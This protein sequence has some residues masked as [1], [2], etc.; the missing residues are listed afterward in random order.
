M[1]AF[2]EDISDDVIHGIAE[3]ER[4]SANEI[5]RICLSHQQELLE[6]Q[7][8]LCPDAETEDLLRRICRLLASF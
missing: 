6:E 7:S 8:S 2:V 4:R 1:D 3:S 5:R